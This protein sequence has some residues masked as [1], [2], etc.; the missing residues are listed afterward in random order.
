MKSILKIMEIIMLCCVFLQF[1]PEA[2]CSLRVLQLPVSVS[3]CPC[4]YQSLACPHNNSSSGQA[5][6][7]K[8]GVQVQKT[9]VEAPI[10]L[11]GD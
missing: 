11:E 2:S 4:V 5:R 7:T 6:I 3:V 9:L 1:L 10:V 8:F